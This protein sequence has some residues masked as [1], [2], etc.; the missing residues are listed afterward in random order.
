MIGVLRSYSLAKATLDVSVDEGL[1]VDPADTLERADIEGVLCPA[2][3]GAL[4]LELAMRLVVLAWPVRGR[5]TWASVSTSPSWALLASS[6]LQSLTGG[7]QV[8]A[9]PDAAPAGGGDGHA[10]DA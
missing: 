6:S 5:Q 1:L 10:S 7:L 9:L 2:V 3:A 4:A 8:V